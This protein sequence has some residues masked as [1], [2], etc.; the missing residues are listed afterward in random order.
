MKK[1]IFLAAM[2]SAFSV[3]ATY[4]QNAP[5]Q[6][7]QTEARQGGRRGGGNFNAAEMYKDLNI[8]KD[9]EA[10]L[11]ALNEE[12]RKKT[13]ALRDDQSLAADARRTKMQELR[14]EREEKEA[15]I[16]TKEQK[17]KLDAARQA[18]RGN[19]GQGGQGGNRNGGQRAGN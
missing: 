5:Q 11:T 2:I 17:A 10:K 16:L 1:T 14:K 6:G 15:A 18:R 3:T 7:A 4:A 8:T 9:Q 12:S 13:Q 19:R